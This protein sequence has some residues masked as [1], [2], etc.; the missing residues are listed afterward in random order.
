[1]S[2][3]DEPRDESPGPAPTEVASR[4]SDGFVTPL[5]IHLCWF[6]AASDDRCKPI[7]K[8]L[9][10]FLHRP[11]EDDPVLRPGLEIPVEY[12]RDLDD[13]LNAL[14]GS[15]ARTPLQAASARIVVVILDRATFSQDAARATMKRAVGRWPSTSFDDRK[16]REVFWP[17]VLDPRW[18]KELGL[19]ADPASPAARFQR[20]LSRGLPLPDKIQHQW[21]LGSDLATVARAAL[22]APVPGAALAT[23]K[24]VISRA[25][26]DGATIAA[27][28]VCQLAARAG[29]VAECAHD[30]SDESEPVEFQAH[31]EHRDTVVIVV[32]TPGY[33]DSARC[34]L[35]LLAAKR[36]RVPIVTVI[37]ARGGERITS[38]YSG[39]HRTVI[40]P[41]SGVVD[42]EWA[43]ELT[44]RCVQAW[45]HATYFAVHAKVALA[46]AGLPA[47]ADI[48]TRR[49]EM[50]DLADLVPQG[51]R[52]LLVYPDP[53]V[54]EAE[55]KLLRVALPSLRMTTPT[56]MIGRAL[57]AKDPIPPLAGRTLA[58]SVSSTGAA[59]IKDHPR[60]SG[61]TEQHLDDVWMAIAVGALHAGAQIAYGGDHAHGGY[62]ERMSRLHSSHRRLGTSFKRQFV[63]YLDPE[64]KR[65][66]GTTLDYEARPVAP[67][68]GAAGVPDDL[69]ETIWRMTIRQTMAKE[70]DGR[71]VIGGQIDER[72]VPG[73]KGYKGPWSGVL[74]E[75]WRT[76][77]AG[78]ALYLIGGFGGVAGEIAKMLLS[79]GKQELTGIEPQHKMRR[80]LSQRLTP[81]RLE[82][83]RHEGWADVA[84]AEAAA[85]DGAEPALIDAATMAK[86][87]L[88]Y[89]RKFKAQASDAPAAWRNHLSVAENERLMSST[90]TTE[91]SQLVFG[92]LRAGAL[93]DRAGRGELR[94]A[95]YLGNIVSAP[96]V[97][98]YVVTYT[99]LIESG[100]LR[101]LDDAM[102]GRLR[103]EVSQRYGNAESKREPLTIIEQPVDTVTLPGRHAIVVPVELPE[104][105]E[106]ISNEQIEELTKAVAR[107]AIALGLQSVAITPFVTRRRLPLDRVIP[108][109]VAAIRAVQGADARTWVFCEYDRRN[110]EPLKKALKKAVD[111]QPGGRLEELHTSLPGYRKD[112]TLV[113]RVDARATRHGGVEVE[114]EAFATDIDVAL[115]KGSKRE[116]NLREWRAFCARQPRHDSAV[117]LGHDLWDRLL[118][119]GVQDVLRTNADRR[120]LLLANELASSLPWEL[121]GD[122]DGSPK[123]FSLAQ[124]MVRRVKT[125]LD[126]RPRVGRAAADAQLRILLVAD[127]PSAGLPSLPWAKAEGEAL[128]ALLAGCRGIA[129]DRLPGERATKANLIEA[130]STGVY[131]VLHYAGHAYF[132]AAHPGRGG[133]RLAGDD[134]FRAADFEAIVPGGR[135]KGDLATASARVAGGAAGAPGSRP[136]VADA[137]PG[138][139]AGVTE[140]EHIGE[141]SAP[142][143]DPAS[144]VVPV[145]VVLSAC[146]SA[147]LA[148]T[149]AAGQSVA[150]RD[151][152]TAPQPLAMELMRAG[153]RTLVGTFFSVG[154]GAAYEFSLEFYKALAAGKSAGAATIE[155]R[156]HLH[157]CHNVDWGNFMLFGDDALTL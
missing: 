84:M 30:V 139:A 70:C 81:V 12:G 22:S 140:A 73:G 128:C 24:I 98:G 50:L 26:S 10:E 18:H 63:S 133:L 53:P 8:G 145:L 148:A 42:A 141:G 87:I 13:L 27:E 142:S 113:L 144:S 28:I 7:A 109:M 136:T 35:E 83:A 15:P 107:R 36:M 116:V 111:E 86:D 54:T 94:F 156:N 122:P 32:R 80:E 153:V 147:R 14:D 58:F 51:G 43:W 105:G 110:Y 66:A 78:K 93:D 17:I 149:P 38:A 62:A 115:V 16:R 152:S 120:V 52:R 124:G 55:A 79:D 100:A 151:D 76:L 3:L 47:N 104:Q 125:Y 74:E 45:L 118:D 20:A 123:S 5:A 97:D 143:S 49:P 75:V 9:Y 90:D 138:D 95:L 155:A 88:R 44:G 34:G 21:A 57:L 68:P 150:P 64:G 121:L 56:T 69:K 114:A 67:F 154:D 41:D 89:W 92:G 61:H 130:L 48:V 33:A 65:A 77:K 101:A 137:E 132:D 25:T 127:P 126:F 157:A 134:V 11:I 29:L 119:S 99:P 31:L 135:R 59:S 112:D 19:A 96:N 71:I 106:T 72:T 39:N 2:E 117:G 85:A 37:A 23:P 40:W 131:D 82:L 1:M 46:H 129:V 91:L 6:A 60:G 103:A 4:A 146:A 108:R 102:S